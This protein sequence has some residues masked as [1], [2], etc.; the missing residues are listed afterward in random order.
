MED[1]L[2]ENKDVQNEI[3]DIDNILDDDVINN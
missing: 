2:A 3:A 1:I